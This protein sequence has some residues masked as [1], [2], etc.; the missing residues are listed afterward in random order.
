M[1]SNNYD[2]IDIHE[3]LFLL[4]KN[5]I[6]MVS[7]TILFTLFVGL[8]TQFFMTEKF[9]SETTIY[10]NPEKDEDQTSTLS[11]LNYAKQMVNTY[12]AFI[13]RRLVLDD[14]IKDLDLEMSNEA[15]KNSLEVNSV[16]NT[17]IISIKVTL[18]DPVLATT[19]ANKVASVFMDKITGYITLG[20]N[21]LKIVDPAIVDD[22]PVSPNMR[23]N[24][25]I[26][27]VLGAMIAVGLIFLR[28]FLNRTIRTTKDVE[29]YLKLPIL[30]AIPNMEKYHNGQ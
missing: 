2:T 25:I 30:G 15:L 20:P 4:K 17:E 19:V 23:L 5:I 21:D 26:G 13:E 22:E 24:L 1:E 7:I 6:L 12:K 27:F 8:Y 14:V 10:V 16:N 18:N 29:R 3:M 11:D 28:E 9:T